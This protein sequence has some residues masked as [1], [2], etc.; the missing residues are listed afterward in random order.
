MSQETVGPQT[1][2]R[3]TP[4]WLWIG[5]FVSLAINLVVLGA[6]IGAVWHYHGS[7]VYRQAGAPRHFGGFLRRLPRERRQVF[8]AI[9]R[10]P[11]PEL[12]SLRRALRVARTAAEDVMAQQSFSRARF[13]EANRRLHEA[14]YRL[15]LERG[16]IFP[17]VA[18]T[19]TAEERRMFLEWRR[20]QRRRWRRWHRK[21]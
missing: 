1:I 3:R 16:R 21:D 2:K 12:E 6:A 7:K 17:R 4:R 10:E 15:R 19:M 18:E 11:R 5:F 14:R 20:H 8:R 13:A 9:F